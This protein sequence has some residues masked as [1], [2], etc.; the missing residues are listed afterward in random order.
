MAAP[1]V[2][3]AVRRAREGTVDMLLRWTIALCAVLALVSSASKA[4]DLSR[5]FTAECKATGVHAYRFE[6]TRSGTVTA[7]G[8]NVGERFG[9]PWVF[10]WVPPD[11]LMLDGESLIIA[12]K[13]DEV[14]SAIDQRTEAPLGVGVWS[15]GINVPLRSVVAAQVNAFSGALGRGVKTRSV[16]FEC[17]FRF[18]AE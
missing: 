4:D 18:G 9:R 15:Y 2:I 6:V 1:S 7:R 3:V 10:R 14:L 5:P 16:E 13:K 11:K 12:S 8:W 17:S